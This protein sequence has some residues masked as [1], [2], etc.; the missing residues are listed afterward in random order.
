MPS[1]NAARASNN[2]LSSSHVT[3]VDFR[4]QSNMSNSQEDGFFLPQSQQNLSE[5]PPHEDDLMR[6]M[7]SQPLAA[8]VRSPLRNDRQKSGKKASPLRGSENEFLLNLKQQ[9][10][11]LQSS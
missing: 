2:W 5:V 4:A 6:S 3:E 1:Q 11:E 10:Q 8:P 9:M 7:L